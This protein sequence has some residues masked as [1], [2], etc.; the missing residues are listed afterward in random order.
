MSPTW[1]LPDSQSGT[2]VTL[3]IVQA[4]PFVYLS[5]YVSQLVRLANGLG[6]GDS[7][8]YH[9]HLLRTPSGW[10]RVAII[11]SVT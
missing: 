5:S 7:R 10:V 4:G 8:G 3:R 6:G 11:E 9:I 2:I 1:R